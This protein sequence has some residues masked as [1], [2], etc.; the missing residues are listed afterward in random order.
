MRDAL[1]QVVYGWLTRKFGIPWY[2][3]WG[4]TWTSQISFKWVYKS[5]NGW[6]NASFVGM[7][8]RD[9]LKYI[10]VIQVRRPRSNQFWEYT[11]WKIFGDLSKVLIERDLIE[12]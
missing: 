2:T 4:K 12:K 8:T 1:F 10:I 11:A 7:V 9:N 5:W 6:T 3:M